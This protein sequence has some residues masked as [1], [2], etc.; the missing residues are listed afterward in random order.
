[1]NRKDYVSDYNKLFDKVYNKYKDEYVNTLLNN[2][3]HYQRGQELA[4]KYNM[5]NWINQ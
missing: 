3:K 1:M 5:M 2:N 4:N